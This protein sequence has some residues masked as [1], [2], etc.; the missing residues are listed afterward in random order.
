MAENNRSE[1]VPL[2]DGDSPIAAGRNR[3]DD[4]TWARLK[5]F[6]RRNGVYVIIILLLTVILIP[7]LVQA[8]RR[9][10]DHQSPDK[11]PSNPSSNTTDLCTSAACVLASANILRSL[12]PK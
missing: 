12:A 6:L 5:S 10:P 7:L 11:T 9:K 8:I 4:S 2:L 1:R 3:Q